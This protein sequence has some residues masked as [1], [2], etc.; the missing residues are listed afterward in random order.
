MKIAYIGSRK[1]G[2]ES[3][4]KINAYLDKLRADDDTEIEIVTGGAFGA[5]TAGMKYAQENDLKLTVYC[6]G[7]THNSRYCSWLE[8]NMMKAQIFHTGLP[9][10]KR[11]T[12]IVRYADL[13]VVTDYGNGTIDAITKALNMKK[14]VVCAGCY[15]KGN[16]FK[17]TPKGMEQIWSMNSRLFSCMCGTSNFMFKT[18][19]PGWLPLNWFFYPSIRYPG[20]GSVLQHNGSV[21][22]RRE[23]IRFYTVLG[24]DFLQSGSL[25]IIRRNLWVTMEIN[26]ADNFCL[27][28]W[29]PAVFTTGYQ[30]Q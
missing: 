28:F 6:P 8:K 16:Y 27:I 29:K 5:D 15:I 13:V 26:C 14:K 11:N 25:C 1:A 18:Y 20:N 12:L 2:P 7:G 3:I 17:K 10:L 22:R 19:C 4:A 23:R 9:F 21:I 24:S 30:E